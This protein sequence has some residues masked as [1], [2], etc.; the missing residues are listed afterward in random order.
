MNENDDDLGNVTASPYDVA[1]E[2]GWNDG[3]DYGY[4]LAESELVCPD[5]GSR[6]AAP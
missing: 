3:V 6:K 1:Y 4:R 2:C 5:C